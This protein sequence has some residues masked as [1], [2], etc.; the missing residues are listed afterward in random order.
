MGIVNVTPDSFSDG[1]H[2]GSVELAVEH[3]EGLIADGADLLDLGGESTRPGATEIPADEQCARVLPVVRALRERGHDLPV[4]VDTRSAAVA[5]AAVE[6]GADLVNDVS[7]L[8]HDP[9][10]RA[11]V[12]ELGVPAIVMHMRGTPADMRRRTEYHDVVRDVL[13]ELGRTLD[14]ARAAGVRELVADPGIG[15]AKTAEQS[16]ALLAATRRLHALDVPLLVGPSR[17]SFLAEVS[18]EDPGAKPAEARHD[19]TTA[20]VTW[21]ASQG[22]HVVRV[23]DVRSAAAACRLVARLVSAA[24]R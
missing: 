11:T 20:A 12:A 7:G 13:D 6:A 9:A 2:L 21:C 4:S 8:H 24:D 18:G 10:M 1:G 15:F 16:M 5:R 3:A 23:H 19:A 14:A 22:T 17:K